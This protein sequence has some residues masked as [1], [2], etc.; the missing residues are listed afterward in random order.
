MVGEMGV[1]VGKRRNGDPLRTLPGG[2]G[3]QPQTA[4]AAAKRL[5]GMAEGPY[6]EDEELGS[7]RRILHQ[8]GETGGPVAL[9]RCATIRGGRPTLLPSAIP[10][11]ENNVRGDIFEAP[12]SSNLLD[13]GALR[14]RRQVDFG[15]VLMFYSWGYDSRGQVVGHLIP[16]E[17]LSGIS[18]SDRGYLAYTTRLFER[19][20]SSTGVNQERLL[21]CGK[22]R[23][24]PSSEIRT[25]RIGILEHNAGADIFLPRSLGRPE[26]IRRPQE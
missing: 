23:E 6:G 13:M 18:D 25:T 17:E 20:L 3:P 24:L 2:T 8:A 4:S 14:V 7:K 15:E 10:L 9:Q 21:L 11:A 1:P 5:F 19:G 16:L 22:V 12:P 26:N